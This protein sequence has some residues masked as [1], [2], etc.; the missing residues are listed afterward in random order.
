MQ[1]VDNIP[2]RIQ[3][4]YNTCSDEEKSYLIKI[5]QELSDTGHSDTYDRIWLA[6]YKEIPVSIDTF[7]ESDTYLGK[8]N[9]NGAAVYPYWRQV[10]KEIF[11]AGNQFHEVVL[12]GATRIGKSST[13][14]TATAYMLYRLMCLRDPQK[15]FGKKEVSKFS[16][17]FFN[18]TKDLAKGVAY[19]EFND[20]LKASPWFNAHGTFSKSERNFYYIPEGG[21]VVIDYGSDAAHGLGQQVFVGF[22][23]EIN[24]AK[25]GVKDVA[26]AKQHMKDTY[27]TIYARVTG[28]FRKNGEV[29]GK[30]F[31]VSSKRSDS[32][33]ME[34][35]VEE[36]LN[37]GAGD[38]MYI[39]DKPQWEVLPA[40]MFSSEKFYIAVGDRHQKGFVVPDTQCFPEALEELRQ[41][42]FQLLTP[43]AD[44]KSAFIADFDIALRDL[45]GISVPGTLSFI[46]QDTLTACI[47]LTRRNPFYQ[48]TLQIGT[49][50]NYSIEEFFHI[51]EVPAIVKRCPLFIHLDLSLNTDDS[52]IS[53]SC[54]TG[55][56]DIVMEDGKTISQPV[57][58]H[59]FSVGIRAPRG[60]KIPYAKITAFICWLRKVGF[61]I[62]RIS[63]DQFQS[64]YMAQLL[65]DQGFT[66]DKLSLDRTP[67]GY[68]SLR[69]ILLENRVDMLDCALL[70][71]ELIHLQ[72]D[73]V[74]GRV[75]HPIG[76]CFTGDTKISLVDGRSISIEELMREQ[77]YKDNWVYTFNTATQRIEPKRISR[78]FQTKLT[79]DLVKVTL[80]N[81][82]CI[83]C[84][85]EHRFMLRDGTYE[86]IGKLSP[87]TSLMPLYTKVSDKGLPGYRMYYEP[88]QD[89][90]HYEHRQ[91]C[92]CSK[93]LKGHVVHHCNYNKLDNRPTNL[94]QLSQSEH[95]Q[96][97]NNSTLDYN[98]V[99]SSLRAWHRSI[100]GT[101]LERIRRARCRDGTISSL[102]ASGRYRDIEKQHRARIQAIE[103][104]YN[105]CWEALSPSEKDRYG[106]LYSRLLDPSITERISASLSQ[107]HREGKFTNAVQALC[108]RIWYTDGNSNVYIKSD[109]TPPDGFYRGRTISKETRDR[110]AQARLNMSA[111]KRAQLSKLHSIDTSN[112]VWITN[113]SVD[114]YIPKDC[115]IP[116]GFRRGRCKIG[117][118]HKIISIEYL[119]QP[120]RV[121]DLTIEDNPNF[122]L[123]AG[124][125]VHN[126]KDIADSFAGSIWN[127]ILH[128]PG[129]PVPSKTVASAIA[130][131]NGR[132]NTFGV[133]GKSIPSVFNSPYTIYNRKR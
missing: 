53:G 9:R 47:N 85:P 52:G 60:D 13:A 110:Q 78:V 127:A 25:A 99:S 102:V 30:I 44:M 129:I 42:G 62:S 95:I 21:K 113:G 96:I 58:T 75:D 57:F 56:K 100:K 16:I 6:D 20:T 4:I 69:S 68:I 66:V 118:N 72:R 54:I 12:T 37:A 73:S 51:N 84:T 2:N 61:N 35:Y 14:I 79:S 88:I 107:R 121:Y 120:C 133:I 39:S 64:E 109:E 18:L 81:G 24:F 19:R 3:Q 111:D 49:K 126:S 83:T 90:W 31:A 112:R 74:S 41:Q 117:K 23:D 33:F 89:A 22:M 108:N 97:H 87:G 71:D 1:F 98:K 93:L 76:G 8:T 80:D 122:A 45:A 94:K 63:R 7:I 27:N 128:N 116:E 26:K 123:A 15:Y 5:L 114:R 43:P 103:A 65:E 32:D 10:L 82:E 38:H 48:D 55:R 17:L 70:Q 115:V 50:D 77:C 67:D 101:D 130:G 124:V 11:D 105:I 132:K 59:V 92:D 104:T 119:H 125:F 28:T 40:S 46:T 86:E 106:T 131:I 36:Q 91:F 29:F 34:A